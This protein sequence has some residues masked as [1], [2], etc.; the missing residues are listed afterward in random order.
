MRE[1]LSSTQPLEGVARHQFRALPHD[2]QAQA[3]RRLSIIGHGE[4]SIAR[5]TGLAVEHVRAVLESGLRA[6]PS[7]VCG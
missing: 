3:I 6:S 2:Q 7:E 5:A 4:E 1:G